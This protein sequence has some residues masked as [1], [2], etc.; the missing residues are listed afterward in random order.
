M[1]DSPLDLDALPYIDYDP[2]EAT[3]NSVSRMIEEEMRTFKP[4]DYLS[5]LEMPET[6]FA[7]CTLVFIG[8]PT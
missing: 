2:D 1:A 6:T 8:V 4:K 7:V 5:H 3:K